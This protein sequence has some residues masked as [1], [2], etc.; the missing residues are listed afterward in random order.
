MRILM[1]NSVSLRHLALTLK[2]FWPNT[3]VEY[4]E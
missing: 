4:K 2:A 1:R 3:R